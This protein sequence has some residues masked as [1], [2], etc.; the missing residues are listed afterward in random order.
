[1]LGEYPGEPT[2]RD[3]FFQTSSIMS[4]NIPEPVILEE[5]IDQMGTHATSA[6]YC[7]KYC[8]I[9]TLPAME[10]DLRLI[11]TRYKDHSRR[12]RDTIQYSNATCE[13]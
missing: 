5:C 4:A 9:S 6:F 10:K 8:G 1:M 2:A 11:C 3:I 7:N 13:G 12:H